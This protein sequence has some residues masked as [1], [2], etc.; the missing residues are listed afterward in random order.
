MDQIIGMVT[1][2]LPK[3]SGFTFWHNINWS[4]NVALNEGDKLALWATYDGWNQL[5][6]NN[7]QDPYVYNSPKNLHLGTIV[8]FHDQP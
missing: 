8:T 4:S 6:M 3:A 7:L 2:S 5:N 1:I